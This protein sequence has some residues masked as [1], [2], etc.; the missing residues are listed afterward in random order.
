MTGG[1]RE[2]YRPTL[3]VM[4]A[5]LTPR[6]RGLRPAQPEGA[7]PS[8]PMAEEGGGTDQW[9]GMGRCEMWLGGAKRRTT[10]KDATLP[11]LLEALRALAILDRTMLS[12]CYFLLWW[13]LVNRPF[14]LHAQAWVETA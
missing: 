6:A 11:A 4:E 1:R 2:E 3:F 7:A 14:L 9:R 8:P 5:L 12:L 13:Q 10:V